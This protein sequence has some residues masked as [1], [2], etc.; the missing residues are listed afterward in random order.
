MY[1]RINVIYK[2]TKKKFTLQ[3]GKKIKCI[4]NS[5]KEAGDGKWFVLL[6]KLLFE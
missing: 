2:Y 4:Q 1:I 5:L 3:K 6:G